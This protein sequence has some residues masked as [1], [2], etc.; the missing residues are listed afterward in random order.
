MPMSYAGAG[1][2]APADNGPNDATYFAD[3]FNHIFA[4]YNLLEAAVPQKDGNGIIAVGG[5]FAT[6]TGAGNIGIRSRAFDANPGRVLFQGETNTGAITLSI[7][8]GGVISANTAIFATPLGVGYGGTNKSSITAGRLLVG[9]GTGTPTELS[10]V[11]NG[12]LVSWNGSAWVASSSG[13]PLATLSDYRPAPGSPGQITIAAGQAYEDSNGQVIGP[14]TTQTAILPSQ[15]TGT[16]FQYVGI[17]LAPTTGSPIVTGPT[18]NNA[19]ISTLIMPVSNKPICAVLLRGATS[20]PGYTIAASDI[21]DVRF[22]GGGGGGVVAGGGVASSA[23][24]ITNGNL[25]SLY[26]NSIDIAK[27]LDGTWA[28][29]SGSAD[30]VSRLKSISTDVSVGAALAN[31]MS[32]PWLAA[33]GTSGAQATVTA[34]TGSLFISDNANR[35]RSLDSGSILSTAQAAGGA[36][37]GSASAGAGIY[38]V[39]ADMSGT[40][41][42][43]GLTMYRQGSF[44]TG[45]LVGPLASVV[46]DGTS[47]I[48]DSIVPT[49]AGVLRGTNTA[50]ITKTSS[51]VATPAAMTNGTW[52]DI[53][54]TYATGGS[55][56]AQ[57]NLQNSQPMKGVIWVYATLQQT[58]AGAG[59]FSSIQVSVDMDGGI[60]TDQPCV[61]TLVTGTAVTVAYAFI[62]EGAH[63][64]QPTSVSGGH[65]F[66][67]AMNPVTASHWVNQNIWIHGEFESAV[68]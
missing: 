33:I 15:P 2:S 28:P 30:S 27:V 54:G 55:G 58:G 42:S 68:T 49:F 26:A 61:Y 53:T 29:V 57:F 23:A 13:I 48:A 14:L 18:A 22:G 20:N 51:M 11:S 34:T 36:G 65:Y 9:A 40:G 39:Y 24:M 17:S 46:W 67:A 4:Q 12:D 6:S 50:R 37:V 3:I 35:R 19:A 60:W 7:S 63:L 62:A 66:R 16:N 44:P 52:T 21:I 59:V 56:F 47:L 32:G 10:G 8:S 31:Q 5:V 64:I 41:P 45:N 25:T 1:R 38:L 43:F